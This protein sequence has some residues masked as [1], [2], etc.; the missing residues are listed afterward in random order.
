MSQVKT[1]LDLSQEIDMLQ[2]KK[3]D[4]SRMLEKNQIEAKETQGLKK[5]LD[6]EIQRLQ[7]QRKNIIQATKEEKETLLE[8][9]KEKIKVLDQKQKYVNRLEIKVSAYEAD[10]MNR[11][12]E[13]KIKEN[14]LEKEVEKA[15]KKTKELNQNEKIQ[16][17]DYN[18]KFK[19]L[20]DRDKIITKKY[21]RVK[22]NEEQFE[23]KYNTLIQQVGRSKGQIKEIL[24]SVLEWHDL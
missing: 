6:A 24:K 23:A 4:E 15:K 17:Q 10:L 2:R 5:G 12:D 13:I 11:E 3:L 19:D 9:I 22:Q 18:K 8:E 7:D 21:D 20:Q 16:I 1:K 14:Y